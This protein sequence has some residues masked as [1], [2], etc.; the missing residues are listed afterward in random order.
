[1]G[2]TVTQGFPPENAKLDVA[3]LD[4][5]VKIHIVVL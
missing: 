3:T 2:Q 1:V 4:V 5:Y